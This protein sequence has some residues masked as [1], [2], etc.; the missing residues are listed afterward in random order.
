VC[1]AASVADS[2]GESV[3]VSVAVSVA[4]SYTVMCAQGLPAVPNILWGGFGQ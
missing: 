1:V 4:L 3:A 2:V